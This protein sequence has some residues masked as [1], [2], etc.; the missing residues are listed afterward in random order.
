[1]NCWLCLGSNEQ[2]VNNLAFA[3]E[4]LTRNYPDIRFS[5]EVET[6]PIGLNNP[7]LFRNQVACFQTDQTI[8]EVKLHLKAIEQQAGR[9]EEDKLHEIVRLDIDLLQADNQVLKPKDMQHTYIK[10]GINELLTFNL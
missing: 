7:A 5:T 1:M 8:D 4:A 2:A 3:R 10:Q 6:I 9:K